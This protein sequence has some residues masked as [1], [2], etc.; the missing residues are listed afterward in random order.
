MQAHL[1]L[2]VSKPFAPL[3]YE[4][5]VFHPKVTVHATIKVNIDEIQPLAIPL[6]SRAQC[7]LWTIAMLTERRSFLCF[8]QQP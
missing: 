1:G 4:R 2:K 6:E 5:G 3:I 7:A 8:S